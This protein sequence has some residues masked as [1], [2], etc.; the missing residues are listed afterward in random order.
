[1]K[2]GKDAESPPPFP[3]GDKIDQGRFMQSVLHKKSVKAGETVPAD[4]KDP[5][6]KSN[7]KGKK[8]VENIAPIPKKDEE[9]DPPVVGEADPPEEKEVKK[10]VKEVKEEPLAADD[11]AAELKF[12]K[13]QLEVLKKRLLESPVASTEAKET[14]VDKPP[15][16]VK[17]PEQAL[18][19]ARDGDILDLVSEEDYQDIQSGNGRQAFNKVLTIFA[20]SLMAQSAE[21]ILTKTREIS[22]SQLNQQLDVREAMWEYFSANPKLK[23]FRNRVMQNAAIIETGWIRGGKKAGVD[24]T[25]TD[26]MLE[27]GKEVY[28]ILKEY[29]PPKPVKTE[30]TP[31]GGGTNMPVPKLK[32]QLK[33]GEFSVQSI[34]Q[35]GKR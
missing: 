25:Y 9:T 5:P 32:A 30:V 16:G 18:K 3:G 19:I 21:E 10:E 7:P 14:T 15:E 27:A 22:L 31:K 34:L 11:P 13:D 33:P 6:D 23:G 28:E 12:Y 35:T 20:R 17:P 26:V 29:E 8:P 24:Y 1:M 2:Q 4:E